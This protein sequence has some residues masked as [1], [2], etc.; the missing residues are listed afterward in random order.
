MGG[1][2]LHFDLVLRRE[3]Q[4]SSLWPCIETRGSRGLIFELTLY[5]DE[6]V[7]VF[8]FDLLRQ[9]GS[10]SSFWPLLRWDGRCSSF[11]PCTE[12]R[13]SLFLLMTLYWDERVTRINFWSDL[14]LRREGRCSSF[15]PCTETR[16]SL[17]LF[18]ILYWDERIT[19]IDFWTDVV[20][21]QEGRC[22]SFWPCTKTRGS[23]FFIFDLVLRREGH[24]LWINLRTISMRLYNRVVEC[25]ETTLSPFSNNIFC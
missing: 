4:C 15:W 6:R 19:R 14:V 13:E 12:T 9:E 17:F 3:G 24:K 8:H 7:V 16:W 5:W 10:C 25:G 23:L 20:M 2:F 21:R 11:W 1:S 22:Y 18:M